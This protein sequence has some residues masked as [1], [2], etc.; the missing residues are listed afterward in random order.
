VRVL[1]YAPYNRWA[2]HGQWEMTVLHA[3]KARGAQVD[4]VLCDGLYTDCD[5]FWQATEP[6]PARACTQCQAEVAALVHQLGMEARWLGRSLDPA[7]EGEARRWAEALEDSELADARYGDLEIGAWVRGSVHSHL[8]TSVLDPADAAV[9]AA[10]RSYAYSGLVAAF[11]LQRLLDATDP[12]VLFLFN[13]R[14]SSLRVAFELARRRGIRVVTHER[15]SRRETLALKENATCVALEPWQ[16]YWDE[17]GAVPLSEDEL[18]DVAAHLHEREHGSGLAWKAFTS[19]P[20]DEADVRDALGL[21]PARPAWVLFTSSDDEVVSEPGWRGDFPSQLDWIERTVE[22]ARRQPGIDLVIRV[23]PN[24]G[25][26]RSTGRNARQLAEL[27]RVAAN[28][29]ENV[30]LIGATDEISSYSLMAIAAVGLVYHSTVALELAC[31]GKAAVVAAGCLVRGMPFVRTAASADYEVVLDELLG[32]APGAVSAEVATLAHRFAHG[33]FFRGIVDFPL[34]AMPHV[35]QGRTL[36]SD[37]AELVP[38]RDAGLDRAAR[39]VLGEEAPCEP[40]G[41]DALAR[42]DAAERAW[43]EPRPVVTALAY[44]DDVIADPQLLAGWAGVFPTSTEGTLVIATEPEATE[45]LIAA[46]AAAGV[47]DGP[48]LVALADTAGLEGLA[49]VLSPRPADGP[50]P[51]FPDAMALRRHVLEGSA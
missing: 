47:G 27:E 26:A 22:H 38:G 33:F 35:T 39:I 50:L 36:W 21:D 41:P 28:L 49:G 25:S 6:R 11:A 32:V 30:R 31:K 37:P 10:L 18:A 42:D 8:R 17:W 3:L 23:H 14:Q 40:P 1:C 45:R 9:A 44:A 2:L 7:E 12:D 29:P 15:G 20:Q 13:G 19:A 46:V 48:D 34:V 51:H 24:T 16:R 43:F 4:Y 5:V